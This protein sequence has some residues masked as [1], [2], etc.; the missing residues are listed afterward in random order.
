MDTL[1]RPMLASPTKAGDLE[2][3]KYPLLA[4]CKIDGIRAT[5]VNGQ[6]MSRT[7]KPIPNLYTRSLFQQGCFEG[8]DGELVVGNPNDKN[9]MQQTMSGVMSVDGEPDVSW[10][11]FDKWNCPGEFRLRAHIAK[12]IV[13]STLLYS[14]QNK[15]VVHWVPHRVLRFKSQLTEF[16]DF[17]VGHGYEGIMLR[18]P[19]GPYKQGRSTLKEGYLLKVKRFE[20][21]EA[22]VLG[23]KEQ[24]RNDNTLTTD[25]RGYAKRSTH[26]DGK[27]AAGILGAFTV[28]D[29][30]T[31]QVFD[32][33][34][35]FTA[36]Q[37]ANL[38]E[39]RNY[40]IGKLVK[41][42]HFPVGVKDLPR[43]PTFVGWRH[44]NDM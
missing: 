11:V 34:T 25:A 10:H 23:F 29:T 42:K 12:E 3:L 26:A 37:R 15:R 6:L 43:F 30:K 32:V 7:M 35:G 38:W 17:A 27:T 18:D 1:K 22:E 39:G 9:L 40:L 36:E 44:K 21:G 24:M 19:N 2:N 31:G 28:R 14:K 5:V 33:G 20:D 41:Y 16:E 8:L 4:S 13:M